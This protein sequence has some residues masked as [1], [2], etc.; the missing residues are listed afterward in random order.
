MEKRKA[1]QPKKDNP[2]VRATFRLDAKVLGQIRKQPNQAKYIE[3]LVI[4]DVTQQDV[5][6]A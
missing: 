2:K 4:K 1:G 5:N 3:A 6:N